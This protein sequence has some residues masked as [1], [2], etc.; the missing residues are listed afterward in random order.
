MGSG[1]VGPRNEETPLKR[2]SS[3]GR[4][5][6]LER[7]GAGGM[8]VVYKAFDP[9]L[10][11]TVAIKLL[12]GDGEGSSGRS[13]LQREAQAMA[14]IAHP[15]VIAVHDVGVAGDRVFFA[16]E[17]VDGEP[18]GTW[19]ERTQPSVDTL[20]EV[21]RRAGAGIAAAHAAGV[22]HRDFKPD[23]VL[24]DREGRPR[25]LDFGLARQG[26]EPEPD[27]KIEASASSSL[28]VQL[29]RTGAVMGTPAY[30]APEQFAG[31]PSDERTDQF[32]F[33]VALYE[34]LV[35]ERPFR[36]DSFATL[37]AAVTLGERTHAS[38]RHGLTPAVM[39]ALDRGLQT[40]PDDR[41]PSMTALLDALAPAT[42]SRVGSIFVG[43]TVLATAVAVAYGLG[44]KTAAPEEAPDPCAAAADPINELWNPNRRQVL[45][46]DFENSDAFNGT[47][48]G[49]RVA[50]ALDEY[51]A[52]WTETARRACAM[53]EVERE[54]NDELAFRAQRCLSGTLSALAD[55]LG[56]FE[57]I[58]IAGVQGSLSAVEALRDPAECT[59]IDMLELMVSP[60]LD[61]ELRAKLAEVAPQVSKAVDAWG[62]G[63]AK[64]CLEHVAA[65]TPA[66]EALDF[67][68]E[69][70]RLL[71]VRGQC[72]LGAG[73]PEV[74]AETRERAFEVALS[75]ADD[76]T[77]LK[78]C[79]ETGHI[80]ATTTDDF[81]AAETWIR[82]A[83][84]L[85][86]R[87]NLEDSE[88]SAGI[89]NVRGILA[90]RQNDPDAAIAFFMQLAELTQRTPNMSKRYVTA[91]SNA[92][93]AMANAGRI[94]D[95]R[96]A[97]QR[98]VDY[99]T[100]HWGPRHEHT[101]THQTKLA[102]ILTIQ[103]QHVE[104]RAAHIAA[105]SAL[106]VS[107]DSAT[108]L[109]MAYTL[110]SLALT[111]RRLGNLAEAKA[112]YLE[113]I[114]IRDRIDALNTAEAA[115]LYV[116]LARISLAEEDY[117]EAE[118]W[119]KMLLDVR[120]NAPGIERA[121][122]LSLLSQV[123]LERGDQ[124]GAR[125]QNQNAE[126]LAL[127]ADS[128][129]SLTNIASVL[130]SIAITTERFGNHSH[131]LELFAQAE[132]KAVATGAE[133]HVSQARLAYA[134]ALQRAGELAKART[135]V[136]AAQE[137]LAASPYP[138]SA[139]EDAETLLREL[140]P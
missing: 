117:A 57:G 44:M 102:Q 3:I 15:N 95:A 20:L 61:D 35:G 56:A 88:Y 109:P 26:G 12:I 36:G 103:G 127:A 123:L 101:A 77:A 135:L 130:Y 63:D 72:E 122:A 139:V 59:D 46:A 58:D 45:L 78:L 27:A 136:E 91:I 32:A 94:E 92:G 21:F 40:N 125:E 66:V 22:I 25:V 112:A 13:R 104:A 5:V 80:I 118:R 49:G 108:S 39:A 114:A 76:L 105:L 74:A 96:D 71:A 124:P 129:T 55:Q 18:L 81:E 93:V 65:A 41:F 68:P 6:V 34:A 31:E 42:Q 23:N 47:S 133:G 33:C 90:A 64:T 38:G 134:R 128:N 89:L 99:A 111:E 51:A 2:G 121:E 97:F 8:G 120:K 137:R 67:R 106:R 100:E 85:A 86:K 115:P 83:E 75:A 28:A 29:T 82:R 113:A 16:M 87:H 43:A 131:A 30:M 84:A 126:A 37:S 70:A 69:T 54:L 24:V 140:S 132:A 73:R 107:P 60:P 119:T 62:R 116:G 98:A 19:R 7:L 79:S 11:R 14:R 110:S 10:D 1:G 48:M 4:Y 9:E 138:A 53:A 52:A 50:D 17:L